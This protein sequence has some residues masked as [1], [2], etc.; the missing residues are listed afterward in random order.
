VLRKTLDQNLGFDVL[1]GGAFCLRIDLV[2][3]SAV[4]GDQAVQ[5]VSVR[6]IGAK[7]LFV[8]KPLDPTT[9]ANLVTIPVSADWPAHLAM[10]AASQEHYSGASQARSGHTQGP[11]PTR[12]L[13]LQIVCHSL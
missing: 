10:P 12:F 8:K 11:K 13:L 5:V 7:G 9:R 6:P 2:L 4:P 1:G 3:V